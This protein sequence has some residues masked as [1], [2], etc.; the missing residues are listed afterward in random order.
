MSHHLTY[1]SLF[2]AQPQFSREVYNLASC[3]RIFTINQNFVSNMFWQD[4]LSVSFSLKVVSKVAAQEGFDLDLGYRLLAVCSAH[5]DKFS[6]EAAGKCS[7]LL[8]M[9]S[10]L[11]AAPIYYQVL[12]LCEWRLSNVKAG[13]GAPAISSLCRRK[14]L[15]LHKM[16]WHSVSPAFSSFTFISPYY[17]R[18]AQETPRVKSS[19]IITL[20]TRG[21]SAEV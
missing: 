21:S 6:C 8:L 4:H 3:H 11:P 9:N 12:P 5:R 16:F 20:E 17:P 7:L 10:K 13:Q 1:P 19:L 18:F 14:Y 2:W 15:V